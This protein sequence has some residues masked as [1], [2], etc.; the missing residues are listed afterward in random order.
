MPTEL[1]LSNQSP[2]IPPS[3]SVLPS[4]TDPVLQGTNYRPQDI[5]TVLGTVRRSFRDG[6]VWQSELQQIYTQVIRLSPLERRALVNLM[7]RETQGSQSLLDAWLGEVTMR[8][9]GGYGGLDDASRKTLLAH[10]VVAQD[11]VNLERVFHAVR[12]RHTGKRDDTTFQM[13]FMQQVSQRG[14]LAQ[15]LELMDRLSD[16]AVR[17]N[18]GAG[19]ALAQIVSR[20]P[21]RAAVAQALDRLDRRA[22]DAMVANAVTWR[23]EL[24]TNT[25]GGSSVT[26]RMDTSL[27][28]LLAR[29]VAATGNPR[30]KAAFV[31]AAGALL[32]RLRSADI[33]L[34]ARDHASRVVAS[35]MSTVIGSDVNGVIENTLLQND[36]EGASSGRLALRNYATAI[37]DSKQGNHL[38]AIALSLQRG[39]SLGQ[40]PM[41]WLSSR[42]RRTGEG[43]AYVRAAVLGDWLGLVASAIESRISDRDQRA[44]YAS[45]MFSGS[46]DAMKEL[47]GTAFPALKLPVALGA[48]AL[49][50]TINRSLLDWR[51]SVARNDREFVRNFYEAALPRH[52]SGVEAR[53][54]WV[55]TMNAHYFASLKRQ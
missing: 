50:S 41:Q 26:T 38:G 24:T 2:G 34:S 51:T 48:A 43:P 33:Q 55:T 5:N 21:D 54:D 28:E 37:I 49:K 44:V 36:R 18:A 15:R 6:T 13:E 19:Q 29:A 8:G 22:T 1:L 52:P 10:L 39:N 27:I 42:Q 9:L 12:S 7:A 30:E 11:P 45:M 25:W 31:A 20:L 16:D 23:N 46:I 17:G 35:A 32:G 14:T 40:D 4:V 3:M 47:A 53:G